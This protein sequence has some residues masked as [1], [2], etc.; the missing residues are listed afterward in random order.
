[1]NPGQLQTLQQH[2]RAAIMGEP[3]PA[4]GSGNLEDLMDAL[5]GPL[6]EAETFETRKR[7][8]AQIGL[9]TLSLMLERTTSGIKAQRELAQLRSGQHDA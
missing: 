8:L 4:L 2:L 3:V 9:A 1:M 7:A 5:R 6:D